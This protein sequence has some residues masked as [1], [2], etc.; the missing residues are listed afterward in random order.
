MN[1]IILCTIFS[2]FLVSC[3]PSTQ[4][5][6]TDAAIGAALGCLQAVALTGEI[7]DCIDVA[8]VSVQ[9]D[10]ANVLQIELLKWSDE[11]VKGLSEA[12]GIPL[13]RSFDKEQATFG[14]VD[15]FR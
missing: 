14:I 8:L 12:L 13:Q 6:A 11:A 1:K 15:S 2:L 3:T 7:Q 9:E 10:V 4:N 5:Q